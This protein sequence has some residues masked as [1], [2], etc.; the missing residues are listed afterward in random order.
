MLVLLPAILAVAAANPINTVIGSPAY[1]EAW[2][3]L[4]AKYS[5]R[6]QTIP[7]FPPIMFF[8]MGPR[9]KLAFIADS[10]LSGADTAAAA[11]TAAAA[12]LRDALTGEDLRVWTGVS[13]LRIIPDQYRVEFQLQGISSS[14][15]LGTVVMF[16]NQTGV[17]II[18][19]SATGS[20]TQTVV[21][22]VDNPIRFLK[23][24]LS[25]FFSASFSNKIRSVLSHGFLSFSTACRHLK[26]TN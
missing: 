22:A 9:R 7:D 18:H 14:S 16:E 23:N 5:D 17:F 1:I 4:T 15:T 26:S 11:T 13:N 24:V 19:G 10:S 6:V 2:Q 21:S 3:R 8:G 12:R 20:A 25:F